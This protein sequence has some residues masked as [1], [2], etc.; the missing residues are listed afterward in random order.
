[1]TTPPPATDL[2][3]ARMFLERLG[4]SPQDLLP[5]APT[6]AAAPTFAEIIPMAFAA[7]PGARQTGP[8]GSAQAISTVT[9][10]VSDVC[11]SALLTRFVT[12]RAAGD[13]RP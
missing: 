3:V 12:T 10:T 13:R 4:I 1:M 2:D 9:T 8:C 7:M 5:N 11:T 6:R